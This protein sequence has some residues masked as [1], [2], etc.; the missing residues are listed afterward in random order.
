MCREALSGV[1]SHGLSCEGTDDE[2][3]AGE[4]GLRFDGT[5][6]WRLRRGHHRSIRR[7]VFV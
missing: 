7:K 1:T 6:P 2:L 3:S 4:G 5:K